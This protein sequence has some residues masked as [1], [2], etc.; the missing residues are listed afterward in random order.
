MM[1]VWDWGKEKI[2]NSIIR[3][4]IVGLHSILLNETRNLDIKRAILQSNSSIISQLL[5]IEILQ[6]CVSASLL[7]VHS[8]LA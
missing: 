2:Q 7:F 1:V 4:K 8:T 6:S 5:N 3:D